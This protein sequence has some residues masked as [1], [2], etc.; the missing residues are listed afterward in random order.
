MNRAHVRSAG[1]ATLP[2]L[3]IV[4]AVLSPTGADGAEPTFTTRDEL[5]R[6]WDLDKD[7][8]V[9]E[10]EVE[11][12]RSKMRR[13]R[14]ELQMQS[15][16]DPLTGRP[17]LTPEEEA[18]AAAEAESALELPEAEAPRPKKR[19]RDAGLPGTRPPDVLAPIPETRP[20]GPAA[21]SRPPT[22]AEPRDA[23]A[24]PGAT[25]ARGPGGRVTFRGLSAG[26]DRGVVTGGAR[27]GGV[28]RPGYGA[29]V[30]KPDL[31]AGRLPAGLPGRRPAPASGGLLPN[32]RTRPTVPAPPSTAPRRTV[33]DYDVY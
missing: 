5:V 11:I 10:G 3:A 33:D 16:I 4:A 14:A 22:T 9:D 15:G 7:G 1:T 30:P 26:E 13:E 31:N 21:D 29:T 8:V 24:Q 23:A 32:L 20:A 18:A 17:R 27:A 28:A 6:K 25:P 2:V 12:A 19:D